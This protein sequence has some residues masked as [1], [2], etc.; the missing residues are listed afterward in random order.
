LIEILVVIAIIS[1]LAA[2]IFPTF[3]SAREKARSAACI[4]NLHQLGMSMSMYIQ[5]N[6]GVY[7]WGADPSDKNTAIWAS[8]PN[9]YP[10]VQQMPLLTEV[11]VPYVHSKEVW[12]CPDDSGFSTL[13]T[14]IGG[15]TGYA[16]N[17]R[18]TMFQAF[19]T[20]YMYRTEISLRHTLD[21]NLSG[22]KPTGDEAGPAEI[23]VLMDGNGYWHGSWTV[24][25]RHYN[26]LMGDDHVVHQN[27]NQYFV[28]G[29]W[30]IRLQ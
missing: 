7:P 8:F 15:N 4:S 21:S 5:D 24:G 9:Y 16:L 30:A 18:P 26:V 17:A 28:T 11:L 3:S 29:S 10:L 23:N 12:H 14:H 2:L 22:L 20:S 6:D 1:I 25:S 19:G 13:D 27:T